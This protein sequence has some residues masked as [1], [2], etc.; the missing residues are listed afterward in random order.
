MDQIKYSVA[1]GALRAGDQ[2]PSVRQLSLDLSVNPTTV[3]KAYSE[4]EHEGVIHSRRGMGTYVSDK[5][6]EIAR[7]QRVE[8]L[9]RL[10]ER[11]VVEAVQLG[12]EARDVER[13]VTELVHRYFPAGRKGDET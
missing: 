13:I 7:E 3:V 4:L 8:I 1:S 11:L 6:V 10:A 5:P 12:A 9:T 2:L